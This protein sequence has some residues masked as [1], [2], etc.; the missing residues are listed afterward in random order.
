MKKLLAVITAGAV[1]VLA[2]CGADSSQSS[3]GSQTTSGTAASQNSSSSSQ[4]NASSSSNASATKDATALF[5]QNCQACHG[6]NLEGGMGPALN[7]VGAK[8]TE[9]QIATKIQNG[10]GAMPAFKNSLKEDD[11]KAL[12]TWLAS[13]K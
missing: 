5:Q 10:G 8:L 4:S 9:D 6:A 11:I 1:L 13:K 2:G 12:A 7:K 3:Q